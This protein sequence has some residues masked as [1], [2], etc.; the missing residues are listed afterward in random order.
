MISLLIIIPLYWL[1]VMA[2]L[3]ACNP[4]KSIKPETTIESV[5]ANGI[6]P[7]IAIVEPQKPVVPLELPT[8]MPSLALPAPVVIDIESVSIDDIPAYRQPI[9]QV[10]PPENKEILKPLQPSVFISADF[11]L[12]QSAGNV[13]NIRGVVCK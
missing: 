4:V 13:I 2:I 10:P 7:P 12:K 9:R 8:A 1:A 5:K 11:E 6:E 3:D